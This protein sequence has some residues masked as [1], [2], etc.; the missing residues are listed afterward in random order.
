MKILWMFELN[1]LSYSRLIFFKKKTYLRLFF[2]E[3]IFKWCFQFELQSRAFS[4]KVRRV[5]R[6]D[7]LN[8]PSVFFFHFVH[9]YS[10]HCRVLIFFAHSREFY[11]QCGYVV[12]RLC[13]QFMRVDARAHPCLKQNPSCSEYSV[14]VQRACAFTSIKE[15]DGGVKWVEGMKSGLSNVPVIHFQCS[16]L[17]CFIRK[18]TGSFHKN[19]TFTFMETITRRCICVT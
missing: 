3:N 16:M 6:P 2:C 8:L 19:P 13:L 10:K 7:S 18:K 14:C 12:N 17:W 15:T 11:G 1:S 5:N 9:F 4:W